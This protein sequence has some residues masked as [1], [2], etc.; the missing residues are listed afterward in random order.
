LGLLTTVPAAGF[1]VRLFMVQHDCGHGA[2]FRHRAAND[3]LGRTI[4]A[5]TLTPYDV[6]R[7]SHAIHYASSGN[8]KSR[9]IGDINTLTV[10]EYLATSRW[11]RLSYRVYQNAI[12]M[13]GLG[14]AYLFFVRHRLPPL[15]L[16]RSGLRPWFSTMI[17]NAAWAPAFRGS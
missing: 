9:G 3:W 17:T 7:W 16:M 14:P 2:L 12:V 15:G 13:F 1:L 6:W 4:G 5:L 10:R 11:R 8:L